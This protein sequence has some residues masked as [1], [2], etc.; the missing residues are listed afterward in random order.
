MIII[1]NYSNSFQENA[2]SRVAEQ[3]NW[4]NGTLLT[5][6]EE[7][8]CRYLDLSS[9]VTTSNGNSVILTSAFV[10][11]AKDNKPLCLIKYRVQGFIH[12]ARKKI[13]TNGFILG[14]D[15]YSFKVFPVAFAMYTTFCWMDYL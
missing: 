10:E 13:L 6:E 2:K 11:P 12:R 8:S 1:S 4:I 3:T 5:T 9:S 7:N 14:M 15:E